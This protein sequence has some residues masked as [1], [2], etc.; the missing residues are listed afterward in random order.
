M[1]SSRGT[2][3][4]KL[5]L[6][7]RASMMPIPPNTEDVGSATDISSSSASR[8]DLI[9]PFDHVLSIS[10]STS[11]YQT[12]ST[13]APGNDP[14]IPSVNVVG[15]TKIP[16]SGGEDGVTTPSSVGIRGNRKDS[17]SSRQ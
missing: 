15:P 8:R 2:L 7:N 16:S 6:S 13:V 10:G 9:S 5:S 14:P 3:V 12:A 11:L 1:S 4:R 17:K